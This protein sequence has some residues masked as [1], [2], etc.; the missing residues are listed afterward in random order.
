MKIYIP[1]LLLCLSCVFAEKLH[2]ENIANE[3][4]DAIEN[5]QG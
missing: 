1:I 3:K 4:K 2:K 5:G